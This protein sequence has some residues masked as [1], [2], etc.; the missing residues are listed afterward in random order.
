MIGYYLTS[1]LA[2]VVF[3]VA[4]DVKLIKP[5]FDFLY[6]A[7]VLDLSIALIGILFFANLLKFGYVYGKQLLDLSKEF[8]KKV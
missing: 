1:S 5:I 4:K 7:L 8:V 6:A 2:T 3:F